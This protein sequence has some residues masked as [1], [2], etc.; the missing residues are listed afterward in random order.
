MASARGPAAGWSCR[1]EIHSVHLS[2]SIYWNL[3]LYFF[4]HLMVIA[5]LTIIC[6]NLPSSTSLISLTWH[7]T[8][9]PS[10]TSSPPHPPPPF[11][12]LVVS[13]LARLSSPFLWHRLLY[14][15][16]YF[17]LFLFLNFPAVSME[18]AQAKICKFPSASSSD[19]A[20]FHQ[21]PVQLSPCGWWSWSSTPSPS[22]SRWS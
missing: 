20:G 15:L 8:A 17:F 3:L 13:T 22:P 1:G 16:F 9:N 10:L 6:R 7:L 18:A 14:F 21:I 19:T 4:H 2:F 11:L 5:E 12:F